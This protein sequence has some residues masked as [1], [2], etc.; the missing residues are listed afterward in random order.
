M[1]GIE[2]FNQLVKKIRPYLT[3]PR[4]DFDSYA[5]KGMSHGFYL[6]LVSIDEETWKI[7]NE[8]ALADFR[9]SLLQTNARVLPSDH[10]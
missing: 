10:A 6:L 8:K 9:L 1:D 2:A 4:Y 7:R 5:K 3:E